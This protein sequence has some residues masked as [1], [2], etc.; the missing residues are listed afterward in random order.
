MNAYLSSK[1]SALLEYGPFYLTQ[2]EIEQRLK[3]YLDEYY[4]FLAISAVHIRDRRFWTFHRNRLKELGH[5]LSAGKL[6][7]AICAKLIDLA[8]NPKRTIE[9]V[10]KHESAR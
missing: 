5:P 10:L 6:S 8:S 1:L 3:E 2:T 7:K 9:A 4:K